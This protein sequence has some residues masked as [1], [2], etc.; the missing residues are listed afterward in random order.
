MIHP[1]ARDDVV[2]LACSALAPLR[3][4]EALALTLPEALAVVVP[5]LL[6]QVHL[7]DLHREVQ[8]AQ[9]DGVSPFGEVVKQPRRFLRVV[10]KRRR[11]DRD[12]TRPGVAQLLLDIVEEADQRSVVRCPQVDP[13]VRPTRGAS[14]H[15]GIHFGEVSDRVDL[16]VRYGDE[17]EEAIV[18]RAVDPV[19]AFGIEDVAPRKVAHRADLGPIVSRSCRGGLHR[20]NVHLPLKRTIVE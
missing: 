11:R 9:L 6:E 4:P 15:P 2:D 8:L 16:P 10:G 1:V 14:K 13:A 3:E 17:A 12:R 7:V 19:V 20:H 18:A 5:H